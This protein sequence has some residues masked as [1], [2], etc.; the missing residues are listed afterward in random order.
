MI[1]ILFMLAC[2]P[3][4]CGTGVSP[5]LL[6]VAVTSVEPPSNGHAINGIPPITDGNSWSFQSIFFIAYI[7]KHASMK[8]MKIIL[9]TMPK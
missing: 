3:L 1:F 6:F 8:R 5:F 9:L 7:G 4:N 2:F